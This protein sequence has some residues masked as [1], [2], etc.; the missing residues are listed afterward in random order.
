M[1]NTGCGKEMEVHI[2]RGFQWMEITVK[3]GNTSPTGFP[4]LCEECG[5]RLADVNWRE[6]AALNGEN[7]DSDY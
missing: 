6:E 4:Y 2:E 5:E 3:C 1:A 7:F